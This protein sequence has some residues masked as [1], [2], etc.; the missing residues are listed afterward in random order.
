M[1]HGQGREASCV[2]SRVIQLRDTGSCEQ[3]EFMLYV[4]PFYNM[5]LIYKGVLQLSLNSL[6]I[7][8]EEVLLLCLFFS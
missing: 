1:A 3:F 6:A 4:M 8:L 5:L 2:S 7:W